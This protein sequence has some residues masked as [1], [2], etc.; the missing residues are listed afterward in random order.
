LETEPGS[1]DAAPGVAPGEDTVELLKQR[2]TDLLARVR[3][4]ALAGMAAEV[5][6]AS[7]QLHA[8]LGNPLLPRDVTAQIGDELKGM[9]LMANMKAT[10][11]ALRRAV[12]FAQA[13]QKLER[14]QEVAA[15]RSF[16]SRAMARGAKEDFKR[17]A[18]MTIESA[19]LTGGV[20]QAGPTRAK[21]VDDTPP[22]RSLAKGE[23]REF[24]R[25][26]VPALTV[27]TAAKNFSTIDW[28]MGG[29]LVGG[30]T[31]DHFPSNEPVQIELAQ[32]GG[33]PVQ[34]SVIAV[35]VEIRKG[36]IAVR[37]LQ[38]TPAL[39]SFLRRLILHRG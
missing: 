30:S 4:H 38:M 16:L 36:G 22:A 10:D 17:A 1:G 19:M 27:V 23:R 2:C 15:A 33:R 32:P 9:D 20:R 8:M 3:E 28:S 14:N 39:A 24:K 37:Y 12:A 25:Y 13:D 31:A 29:M 6:E 7:K 5:D 26:E 18:E 11:M 35:R 21:P 34:A